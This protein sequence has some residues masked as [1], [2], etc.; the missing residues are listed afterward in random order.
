MNDTAGTFSN[1]HCRTIILSLS[2]I[3][4]VSALLCFAQNGGRSTKAGSD[5]GQVTYEEAFQDLYNHL[6][7]HYVYFE[8]KKIDWEAVGKELLPQAKK[9][10][11]DEEFGLLCMQLV[12]RLEDSH[13]QLLAGTAQLPAPPLPKWGP[14]FACL[15]DDKGKPVVYY[16]DNK[17]S[18]RQGR[19]ENRD[20]G[21]FGQWCCSQAGHGRPH[22]AREQV[23]RIFQPAVHAV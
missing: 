15:I 10:K 13:A 19:R 4:L 3:L 2:P 11:T 5:A 6:K 7:S 20:D 18:R 8:L 14:G 17:G 23:L 12:A 16:I 1:I 21:G 9:V 22:E